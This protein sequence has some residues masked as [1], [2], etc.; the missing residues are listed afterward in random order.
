MYEKGEFEIS[1]RRGSE[2]TDYN[3]VELVIDGKKASNKRVSISVPGR[4]S[5][6]LE[7]ANPKDANFALE[8][9]VNEVSQ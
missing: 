1:I 6:T 7:L 3:P 9:W 4:N 8:G 5:V 2:T